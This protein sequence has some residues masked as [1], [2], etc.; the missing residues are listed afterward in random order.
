MGEVTWVDI[1]D[2]PE[3]LLRS[4]RVGFDLYR[5]WLETGRF[6]AS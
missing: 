5:A 4:T 2:P 6:Q 3:P 1:D